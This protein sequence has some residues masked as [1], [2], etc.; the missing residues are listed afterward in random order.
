MLIITQEI[1]LL[2]RFPSLA[3]IGH[4]LVPFLLGVSSLQHTDH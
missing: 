2:R 1:L 4:N 3:H